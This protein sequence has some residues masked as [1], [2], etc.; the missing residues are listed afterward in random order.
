MATQK[1]PRG[2]ILDRFAAGYINIDELA[3]EE[4]GNGV[5]VT[6]SVPTEEE[7]QRA[8]NLLGEAQAEG[9]RSTHKIEVRPAKSPDNDAASI[10][11]LRNPPEPA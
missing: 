5:R 4:T 10:S 11:D 9:I 8:L 6:G 1:S 7:R 3:V 2:M